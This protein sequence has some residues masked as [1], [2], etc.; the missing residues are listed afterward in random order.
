MARKVSHRELPAFGI[1]TVTKGLLPWQVGKFRWHG[2]V[3]DPRRMSKAAFD[4]ALRHLLRENARTNAR[5]VVYIASQRSLNDRKDPEAPYSQAPLMIPRE[6][7][8]WRHSRAPKDTEPVS[9]V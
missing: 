4:D 6:T 5:V 2:Y 3:I 7:L 1:H 8:R 9:Y